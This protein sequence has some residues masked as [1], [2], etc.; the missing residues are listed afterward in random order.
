MQALYSENLL[1]PLPFDEPL[2]IS[3]WNLW[4]KGGTRARH[5]A[6]MGSPSNTWKGI[7]DVGEL[8]YGKFLVQVKEVAGKDKGEALI[9]KYINESE[10]HNWLNSPNKANP[11]LGYGKG[12]SNED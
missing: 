6:A 7:A 1:T 9:K 8:F 11:I 2:E 10:H 4:H 5:G 3:Y 12:I